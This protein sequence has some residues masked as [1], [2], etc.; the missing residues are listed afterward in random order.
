MW[1]V[2]WV[3]IWESE[4]GE[5][6][7]ACPAGCLLASEASWTHRV[8]CHRSPAPDQPGSFP[9]T[10]SIS[11]CVFRQLSVQGQLLRLRPLGPI[12]ED[13]QLRGEPYRRFLPVIWGNEARCTVHSGRQW[14][15]I[16]FIQ[17]L[18]T[19]R[20]PR[21]GHHLSGRATLHSRTVN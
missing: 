20:L 18:L 17:Q 3:R 12:Q 4:E 19:G 2:G 8:Q 7:P 14:R 10:P 9:S 16:K 6:S 21:D 13:A 15:C 11:S 1:L 5:A